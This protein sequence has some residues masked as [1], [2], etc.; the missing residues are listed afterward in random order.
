MLHRVSRFPSVSVLAVAG[1]IGAATPAAAAIESNDYAVCARGIKIE[2]RIEACTRIIF[3]DRSQDNRATAL[4]NR[5]TAHREKG[6]LSA[7][8]LDYDQ[9]IRL[10]PNFASAFNNRGNTYHNQGKHQEALSDYAEAI[11]HNPK[12]A[13]ALINRGVVYS[14]MQETDKAIEDFNQAIQLEAKNARAHYY[15]GNAHRDKKDYAKAIA[16][17]DTAIQMQKDY[18]VAYNNRAWV[19]CLREDFSSC[20]ADAEKGLALQ[21]DLPDS[22]H[23]KGVALRGLDRKQDA[24]DSF[25]LAALAAPTNAQ[26]V[27]DAQAML[28]AVGKDPGGLDGAMGNKTQAEIETWIK[29]RKL[30]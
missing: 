7:A 19:H 21:P 5:G 15:R 8:I 12:L 14:D 1:A 10:K 6:D 13:E 2:S 20:L 25:A 27:Q 11:R 29:S 22:L 28:K 3:E 4:Y 18:A 17:Y 16:D 9:A 26:I 30:K 23:T 24:M